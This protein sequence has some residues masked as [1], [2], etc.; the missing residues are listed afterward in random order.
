MSE[1][2]LHEILAGHR[3]AL[4]QEIRDTAR[5]LLLH[6]DPGGKSKTSLDAVGLALEAEL[7]A[8]ERMV[9]AKHTSS[10]AS[11]AFQDLPAA[12]REAHAQASHAIRSLLVLYGPQ[13]AEVSG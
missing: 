13:V 11:Y 8:Y 10:S 2:N 3:L 6:P 9:V 7:Q 5:E 1:R 4:I 12:E